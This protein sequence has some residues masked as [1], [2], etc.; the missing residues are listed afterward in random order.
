[1]S[2]P[3]GARRVLTREVGR[4]TGFLPA[5][6]AR[7]REAVRRYHSHAPLYDA[8]TLAAEGV[9]DMAIR[10]LR[11]RPGEVIIDA[12]CGTGLNFSRIEHG[13]GPSGRLIGV[14]LSPAML[15]RAQERVRANGWNNVELVNAPVEH[16]PIPA[17]ADAALFCL[18]HDIVR[19]GAALEHVLAAVR[20]GGRVVV[21]GAKWAHW[22]ALPVNVATW[23]WNRSY[24]TTFEGFDRPWTRLA[25]LVPELQVEPLASYADG[26]YVAWGRVEAARK[27]Q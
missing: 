25:D 22:W 18:T 24:V 14:E 20:P 23:M 9:R 26:A 7:P 13:I 3:N 11:P 12:G 10:R 8:A 17:S 1:M 4:V 2:W 15:A 27:K 5:R 21:A 6:T 16:A 19:S